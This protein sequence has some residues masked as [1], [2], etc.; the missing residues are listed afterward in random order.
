MSESR[1]LRRT[2][3]S[4]EYALPE[5]KEDP[6]GDQT[7]VAEQWTRTMTMPNGERKT[8]IRRNLILIAHR[9][10][11]TKGLPLGWD[12]WL[13]KFDPQAEEVLKQIR[14]Q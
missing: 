12:E 7:G 13:R 9:R 10:G 1:A 4:I 2:Q 3:M 11:W 5:E 6:L 14:R 8:R